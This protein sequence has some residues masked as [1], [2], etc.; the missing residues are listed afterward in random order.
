MAKAPLTRARVTAYPEEGYVFNHWEK[1]GVNIGSIN[2]IVA[3]IE[4]NHTIKAFLLLKWISQ[5]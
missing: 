5:I 2:P 4:S 1:D 3:M